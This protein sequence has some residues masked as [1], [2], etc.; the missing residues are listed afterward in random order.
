M[1]TTARDSMPESRSGK[2]LLRVDGLVKRFPG[3]TALGGVSF[4][5]HAGEVHVL[6]GENG[7]GKS[8]LIKCLAGVY[9]PD[10][11]QVFVDG[12][13]VTLSTTRDAEELGIATIHQEFNLIPELSVAENVLLGR[14]P[15]RLGIVDRQAMYDQA[16]AALERVGLRIDPRTPVRTLGVARQQLVE[17][18]KAL[19]LNARI[20][21]LD[22][23]TA[24]LTDDEVDRLLNLM[25]ELRSSGVGLVFI[26]HHL[27]EIRRI[28]DRVTILRDGVGVGT[29]SATT[30]SDELVRLMV[31]RA[32]ASQY[33]RVRT[34]PGKELLRV[35]G[36]S[37]PGSFEDITLSVRAGEVVG[38][39]GLVGAGRTELLRAILGADRYTTGSVCLRGK[40]VRRHDVRASIHAGLGL[41]PE[42]R[43]A[44]GLVLGASVAE[45]LSLVSLRAATRLGIVDRARLERGARRAVADLGIR[46]PSIRSIV[47]NLSGG[48]QQKVVMGKWLSADPAVLLLDEPTRGVDV[49]AKVEIYQLINELTASGRGVLLVSSDLPEVLGMSDRILVMAHGRLVG[50]LTHTE[51]TQDAVMALAVKEVESSRAH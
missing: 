19:S 40:P 29:V 50:E 28:G 3:V 41:V 33:P 25:V 6:L 5:L 4:R 47:K 16:S 22:E 39:A 26:S 45:N 27:E 48:N 20:L 24:T 43:K 2:E 18:A 49:G 7:A 35:D 46:T 15:R 38:L 31:G 30:P 14:P 17:I 32:I 8:T 23:P 36:L 51:A 21:I 42:D 12:R 10:E 34:A 44:Q 9:Q 13:P 37:S 11:G 1:N